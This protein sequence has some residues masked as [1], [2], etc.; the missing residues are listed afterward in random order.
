[1]CREHLAHPSIKLHP[2]HGQDHPAWTFGRMTTPHDTNPYAS[3]LHKEARHLWFAIS[4]PF[5]VSI[6]TTRFRLMPHCTPH[7]STVNKEEISYFAAEN[8][9]STLCSAFP[10]AI[11]PRSVASTP[12]NFPR[13]SLS[14]ETSRRTHPMS[15]PERN[16]GRRIYCSP[17]FKPSRTSRRTLKMPEHDPKRRGHPCPPEP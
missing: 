3:L 16:I 2:S 6:L 12:R 5:L 13:P 11:G 10:T 4:L 8:G 1:M 15:M 7:T 17:S 14:Q 9:R